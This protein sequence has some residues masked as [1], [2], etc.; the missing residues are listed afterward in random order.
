MH[1]DKI[2]PHF[3][4]TLQAR[5]SAFS[6]P[7]TYSTRIAEFKTSDENISNALKK[8]AK[9]EHAD[10]DKYKKLK[11][12]LKNRD[13]EPEKYDQDI[14]LKPLE[15][16]DELSD[17]QK[18]RVSKKGNIEKHSPTI[19]M[20]EQIAAAIRFTAEN[21]DESAVTQI[22]E[23][24]VQSHPKDNETLSLVFPVGLEVEKDGETKRTS[25]N[26]LP[27]VHAHFMQDAL[28]EAIDEDERL[29][30]RNINVKLDE[31]FVQVSKSNST[32]AG[33]FGKIMHPPLFD[34]LQNGREEQK[35]NGNN[36]IPETALIIEDD[37]ELA[38]TAMVAISFVDAN[39][40]KSLGMAVVA[41]SPGA[42]DLPI[43]PKTKETINKLIM[44]SEGLESHDEAEQLF[45]DLVGEVGLSFDRISNISA[46]AIAAQLLDS[47]NKEHEETLDSLLDNAAISPQE[48]RQYTH[49]KGGEHMVTKAF[50][51]NSSQMNQ[52]TENNKSPWQNF[53]ESALES[54]DSGQRTILGADKNNENLRRASFA[55]KVSSS[56]NSQQSSR[57][58]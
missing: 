22:K 52:T 54:V 32:D 21:F 16:W 35:A 24:F 30:D 15:H 37:T 25:R 56:L 41:A 12:S 19:S 2:R 43:L 38:M 55:E 51:D 1:S 29:K 4:D 45:N 58:I 40:E 9:G 48:L 27:A 34:I 20:D 49:R 57:E 13:S 36:K 18:W 44:D 6:N 33:L 50:L 7:I 8:Y 3:Y 26:V 53:K 42:V 10:P 46:I 39:F 28:Q 23:H 14:A 47:E 11:E 5:D 31:S 17:T